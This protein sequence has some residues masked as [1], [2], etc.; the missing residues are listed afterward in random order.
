M[1]FSAQGSEWM[2]LQCVVSASTPIATNLCIRVAGVVSEASRSQHEVV[3]A[4]HIEDTE[5]ACFAQLVR[6]EVRAEPKSPVHALSG[7]PVQSSK[8]AACIKACSRV[9]SE[10]WLVMNI[11]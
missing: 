8:R 2:D 1:A 4:F 7:S 6:R 9:Q 3:F 10:T 5:P 11:V